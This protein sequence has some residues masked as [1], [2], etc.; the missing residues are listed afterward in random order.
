MSLYTICSSI[1][2]SF[3]TYLS[4]NYPTIST[5]NSSNVNKA[6]SRITSLLTPIPDITSNQR[7]EFTILKCTGLHQSACEN[8]SYEVLVLI[9]R[10]LTDLQTQKLPAT[11][12]PWSLLSF[13]LPH[14]RGAISKFQLPS[15]E[16]SDNQLS[17]RVW[18]GRHFVVTAKY[19]LGGGS[20]N[21]VILWEACYWSIVGWMNISQWY[22]CVDLRE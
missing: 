4:C 16:M 9:S 18:G 10:I 21:L 22:D 7:G 15:R 12:L 2:R 1:H 6:I 19:D 11:S 3:L 17:W 13:C 20:V 14:R 8:K 5:A